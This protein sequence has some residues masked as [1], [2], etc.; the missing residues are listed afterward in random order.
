[1]AHQ[2]VLLQPFAV[3]GGDERRGEV[4]EAGRH[5]VDDLAAP[6]ELLHDGSC[7]G[8]ACPCVA[9]QR[10]PGSVARNGL[11]VLDRQVG[12]GEDDVRAAIAARSPGRVVIAV[13]PAGV[14]LV[15]GR[16]AGL[17]HPARIVG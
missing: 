15:V 12:A 10:R 8:D 11:D 14:A 6:D 1:V 13:G 5:A 16:P 17:G 9:I 7:L 3:L 2:E 4:P